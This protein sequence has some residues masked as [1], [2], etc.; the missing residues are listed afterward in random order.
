MLMSVT[1]KQA[2]FFHFF[3]SNKVDFGANGRCGRLEAVFILR[4]IVM[5]T[6]AA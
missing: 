2:A 6:G 4:K 3:D 1:A 5:A